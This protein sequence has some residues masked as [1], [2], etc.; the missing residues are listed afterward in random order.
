MPASSESSETNS[1]LGSLILLTGV[2][3]T[4]PAI[5]RRR[6]DKT[7]NR[8]LLALVTDTFGAAAD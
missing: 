1:G 8:V 2:R 4:R 6:P 7:P 5:V 3:F